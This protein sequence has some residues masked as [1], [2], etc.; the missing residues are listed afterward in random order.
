MPDNINEK[1]KEQYDHDNS[2]GSLNTNQSD[3][4]DSESA[5]GNS[6]NTQW[7]NW[8]E[9]TGTSL[10][11]RLFHKHGGSGSFNTRWKNW[12]AFGSTHSFNFDGSNDYLDAGNGQSLG[13]SGADAFSIS[14]WVYADVV[15]ANQVI[16]AFGSDTSSSPEGKRVAMFLASTAKPTLAFWGN[17]VVSAGTISAGQWVHL[18]MTFAGGNRTSA[19][20]K[21]YINGVS[22]TLSGG[23]ASALDLSDMD[24]IHIG[25]DQT[26]DQ[27]FNGLIDEVAIWDTALSASD[28]TS[29]YNNGKVVDLSK[30]ASYGTDRTA[31]LKLMIM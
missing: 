14:A 8:A 20:S 31:N 3:F 23:T 24:F 25:A 6:I 21:I 30:S 18:A 11:T 13:F 27:E 10:N 29:V 1:I 16:L 4:L 17:D 9:G 28:V 26:P 2:G 5:S 22:Q 12:I 7:R 15:N 19:N